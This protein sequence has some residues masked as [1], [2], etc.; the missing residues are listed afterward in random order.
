MREIR[1]TRPDS[2]KTRR[3]NFPHGGATSPGIMRYYYEIGL[4]AEEIQFPI[5]EATMSNTEDS[6]SDIPPGRYRHFK[7]KEYSVIGVAV[8]SETGE[9]LVVYRPLYGTHQLTVRPKVMFTEQID[10]DGYHGP[11]FQLVQSS[12]PNSGPLP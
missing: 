7:G 6:D 2:P 1:H 4:K 5:A 10:R 12:D 9:E 3:P 8:H 11:R